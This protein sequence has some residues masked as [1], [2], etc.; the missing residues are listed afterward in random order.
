ML[1]A[2]GPLDDAVVSAHYPHILGFGWAPQHHASSR[3]QVAPELLAH[4]ST[5]R[6]K[7]HDLSGVVGEKYSS[8]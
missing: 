8:K 7:P 4:G 5:I 1:A 2:D 6:P 3:P